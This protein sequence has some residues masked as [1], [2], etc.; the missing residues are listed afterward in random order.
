MLQIR[1]IS[2]LQDNISDI[3]NCVKSG[4]SVLLTR[5]GSGSMVVMSTESY[6]HLVGSEEHIMDVADALAKSSDERLTHD[7]V[8]EGLRKKING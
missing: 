1:P 7:Q 5:N 2:D 8:F 4:D 6:S 3:E